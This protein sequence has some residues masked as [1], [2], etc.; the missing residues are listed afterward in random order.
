M[1]QQ[2]ATPQWLDAM[3]EDILQSDIDVARNLL[4]EGRAEKDVLAVLVSRKIEPARA[5]RLVNDLKQGRPVEPDEPALMLVQA[6]KPRTERVPRRPA[7]PDRTNSKMGLFMGGLLVAVAVTVGAIAFSNHRTHKLAQSDSAEV[8]ARQGPTIELGSQGLLVGGRAVNRENV[9]NV[10]RES[11]GEPSRT[12]VVQG[13]SK[14]MYAYDESGV[15]VHSVG[16]NKGKDALV[17]YFD[18]IGGENGTKQPFRGDFLISGNPVKADTD[19]KGLAAI[20]DLAL[21]EAPTNSIIES[22]CN[23]VGVSFAYLDNTHRLSMVQIE[24][25]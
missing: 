17:L 18:S 11:I 4:S 22:S 21:G 24:L 1:I 13:H 25:K 12:N 15:M 5:V 10:L 8:R 16:A 19:A 6:S 20:R 14:V 3:I 7:E 9:L 23:G 2:R